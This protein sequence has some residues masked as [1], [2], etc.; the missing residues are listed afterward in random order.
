MQT[1]LGFLFID[2]E[3]VRLLLRK[4]SLRQ[5]KAAKCIG[6][7]PAQFSRV[8]DGDRPVRLTVFI[9]LCELIKPANPES[10]IKREDSVHAS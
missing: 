10:L 1:S 6:I 2:G 4:R 3:L 9:A 5:Q 7:S 8:L